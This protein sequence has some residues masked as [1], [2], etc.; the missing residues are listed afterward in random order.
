MQKLLSFFIGIFCFFSSVSQVNKDSLWGVWN[1]HKFDDS[2]RIKAIDILAWDVYLFSQ[3]DSA[4]LIAQLQYN[5]AKSTDNKATMARALSIQG[6]SYYIQSNF[7]LAIDYYERSLKLYQAINNKKGIASVYN[8]LGSTYEVLSYYNKAIDYYQKSIKIKEDINDVKGIASTLGNLGII[9]SDLGNTKKALDH[10]ERS[11][12]IS[13]KLN[14]KQGTA[15]SLENAGMIYAHTGNIEKAQD[16]F[17][18]ALEI[19][20]K[21][22]PLKKWVKQ[23]PESELAKAVKISGY[24]PRKVY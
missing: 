17:K 20:E 24:G 23:N 5:L 2:L 22:I 4:F 7:L 13:K 3:P 8:N 1:D 21:R 12:S 9:Y 19:Y 6:S 11:L 16:N 18:E 14:D 10:I 15:I